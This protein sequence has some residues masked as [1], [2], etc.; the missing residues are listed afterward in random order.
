MICGR[1]LQGGRKM[2][3]TP[4]LWQ[5]KNK[6]SVQSI[7][8]NGLDHRTCLV[9]SGHRFFLRRFG[10]RFD[11]LA[12]VN[13]KPLRGQAKHLARI[14][15]LRCQIQ[16]LQH[17]ATVTVTTRRQQRH[18]LIIVEG[19]EANRLLGESVEESTAERRDK[20]AFPDVIVHRYH[21]VRPRSF[22]TNSGEE[23][24]DAT[25]AI[26]ISVNAFQIVDDQDDAPQSRQQ[27]QQGSE[28][29]R[30]GTGRRGLHQGAGTPRM[31]GGCHGETEESGHPEGDLVQGTSGQATHLECEPGPKHLEIL[32]GPVRGYRLR[33]MEIEGLDRTLAKCRRRRFPVLTRNLAGDH[34][35]LQTMSEKMAGMEVQRGQT[36]RCRQLAGKPSDCIFQCGRRID[37]TTV[38]RTE[39]QELV[40]P[41]QA[42]PELLQQVRLSESGSW[43]AK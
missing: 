33:V 12:A 39:R 26:R 2:Q 34:Q 14:P 41:G 15:V 32:P 28:A 37:M 4:R 7:Q 11:R 36:T 42:L 17:L 35:G 30:I 29:F 24:G 25:G 10:G 1:P 21:Q 6:P 22:L 9:S 3:S 40:S 23:T 38:E 13:L 16:L 5:G 43:R 19:I 18:D 20:G 8:H 27:G 31:L